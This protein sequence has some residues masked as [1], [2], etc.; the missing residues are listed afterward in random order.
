MQT[1]V[2]TQFD[3]LQQVVGIAR[4]SQATDVADLVAACLRG[5]MDMATVSAGIDLWCASPTMAVACSKDLAADIR[6]KRPFDSIAHPD[7]T[8]FDD[9]QRVVAIARSAE[10]KTVKALRRA[11]LESGLSETATT[12]GIDLWVSSLKA[13]T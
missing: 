5:G 1:T 8:A 7:D 10:A 12:R 3:A 11:C 6:A 9:L 2:D 13:T 4:D